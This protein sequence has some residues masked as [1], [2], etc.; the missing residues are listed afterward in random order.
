VQSEAT[1]TLVALADTNRE[2]RAANRAAR[3]RVGVECLG[4]FMSVDRLSWVLAFIIAGGCSGEHKSGDPDPADAS[5]TD[6]P[7]AHPPPFCPEPG[8]GE[9]CTC[10]GTEM[11]LWGAPVFSKCLEDGTWEV[12]DHSCVLGL[13]CRASTECPSGEACCGEPYTGSWG[14][15][16]S[17]SSCRPG[18]CPLDLLQLCE[19]STECV[20][21]GF[22]CSEMDLAY[23][24]G[25]V[26]SCHGSN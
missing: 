5:E 13:N 1:A 23:G 11:C 20:Q 14:T 19:S 15:Q 7:T 9:P 21:N 10:P 4:V 25:M 16:I 17:S 6:P 8:S 2:Q 26:S 22:A 18:P 3:Q 12:T 24:G